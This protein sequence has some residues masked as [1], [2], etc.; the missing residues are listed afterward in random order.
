MLAIVAR[1][2]SIRSVGWRIAF[3]CLAYQ[4]LAIWGADNSEASEVSRPL[5]EVID[6]T[7][8]QRWGSPHWPL[9]DDGEFVRRIH[10]DLLGRIPSIAE[11]RAFISDTS[12]NKREALVDR[13]LADPLHARRMAIWFDVTAM[14]RRAATHVPQ[15]E[16]LRFLTDSF[17]ADKS[18]EQ[19][20]REM[21]VAD[22]SPE[23]NRAAA[24]FLLEREVDPHLLTRDVGR[25]VFGMDLQCAQCH[26]HPNVE[27]YHQADYYG[28][29]A[30]L[31]RSAPF[32]DAEGKLLVAEKAEGEFEFVSVFTGDKGQARVRLPDGWP[33]LEPPVAPDER[34]VVAPADGI[35][36]VPRASRRS[37]IASSLLTTPDRSF[38]RNWGNRLW[39]LL[40]GRGLVHPLDFHHDDN[41]ASHPE[42]LDALAEALLQQQG[43][44]RAILRELACSR[45]YQR[46]FDVERAM[47]ADTTEL[48]IAQEELDQLRTDLETAEDTELRARSARDTARRDW[49]TAGES[50]R[51]AISARLALERTLASTSSAIQGSE[52]Q[53]QQLSSRMAHLQTAIEELQQASERLEWPDAPPLLGLLRERLASSQAEL[54]QAQSQLQV[55]RETRLKAESDLQPASAASEELEAKCAVAEQQWQA[56]WDHWWNARRARIV[57]E[58]QL[59]RWEGVI[60]R[61]QARKEFLEAN[62]M[63]TTLGERLKALEAAE[64]GSTDG[65]EILRQNH[66]QLK[67]F[68][69]AA[70]WHEAWLAVSQAAGESDQELVAEIRNRYQ[71]ALISAVMA[72]KAS[73]ND[74]VDSWRQRSQE[75]REKWAGIAERQG[76]VAGLTGLTPEQLAW[77]LMQATGVLDGQIAACETELAAPPDATIT[78]PTA[79]RVAARLMAID[80]LSS[81]VTTFVSLFG[82]GAGQSQDAFF[83]TADQSLFLGNAGVLQSWIGTGGDSLRQR[84]LA[85]TTPELAIEEISLTLFSR[86]ATPEER[87][88]WTEAV[89]GEQ[90]DRQSL[91]DEWIWAGLTSVEFRFNR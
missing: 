76:L 86:P 87:L 59:Y 46:T 34:Y 6:A 55:Q 77:S 85:A 78:D 40:F 69:L 19:L 45:A 58:D 63:A 52:S 1:A 91:V 30:A 51:D 38:A 72:A 89:S 70:R 82:H 65:L 23:Q 15:D 21:L 79:R 9:A 41:P 80:R 12:P 14:E 71:Q 73:L 64:A 81:S 5:R 36:P 44:T 75:A 60:E 37:M 13:L 24:K 3:L 10:L 16:W 17:A 53:S 83:A 39:A 2:D 22:G 67:E 18:L 66:G 42:L 32:K 57:L 28:L 62:L 27:S 61:Q 84:V 90:T 8:A 48:S 20:L 31:Q 11:T 35:R 33:L 25:I 74:E 26:D 4:P 43:S 49:V 56:A 7:F 29:Y 68:I 47:A 54:E 50:R 88:L